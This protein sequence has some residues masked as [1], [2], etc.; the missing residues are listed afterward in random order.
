MMIIVI[1]P[2]IGIVSQVGAPIVA[3]VTIVVV[4]VVVIVVVVVVVVIVIVVVVVV[5]VT[6]TEVA[7]AGAAIVV[8]FYAIGEPANSLQNDI[9]KTPLNCWFPKEKKKK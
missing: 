2:V 3:A 8:V 6:V 5:V 7:S 9:K 4:V 1:A